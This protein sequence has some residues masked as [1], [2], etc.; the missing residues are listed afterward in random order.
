M[1]RCVCVWVALA[2]RSVFEIEPIGCSTL[3]AT[4]RRWILVLSASNVDADRL[5]FT[6]PLMQFGCRLNDQMTSNPSS[7]LPKVF[8]PEP[9]ALAGS[10]SLTFPIFQPWLA[11][12]PSICP[13]SYGELRP[14]TSFSRVSSSRHLGSNHR[15]ID[16]WTP[17]SDPP[18]CT[19][20]HRSFCPGHQ[21]QDDNTATKEVSTYTGTLGSHNITN[22]SL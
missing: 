9:I 21:R 2:F 18:A 1:H 7:P 8:C 20:S 6:G 19:H 13:G 10:P 17:S 12:W 22:P 14:I 4:I 16:T 11:P 3:A 15:F 5:G